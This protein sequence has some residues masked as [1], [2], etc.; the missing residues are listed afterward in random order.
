M[1]TRP[2]ELK[3]HLFNSIAWKKDICDSLKNDE[4]FV[5]LLCYKIN[6]NEVTAIWKI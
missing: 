6:Y 1:N 4:H 3:S 5:N 2:N